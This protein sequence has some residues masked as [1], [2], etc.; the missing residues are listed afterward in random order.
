MLGVLSTRLPCF[1][2]RNVPATTGDA[3][4]D[5]ARACLRLAKSSE[6]LRNAG[7]L[8]PLHGRSFFLSV[9][10]AVPCCWCRRIAGFFFVFC[11]FFLSGQ[12]RAV[13]R[14]SRSLSV[15]G[16]ISLRTARCCCMRNPCRKR[17]LPSTRVRDALA[18]PL[19]H[20]LPLCQVS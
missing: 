3:T 8:R 13:V 18:A 2:I 7:P 15:R 6:R 9:T 4:H 16:T 20:A 1:L 12:F 10:T 19:A 11:F 5:C 14:V 17:E